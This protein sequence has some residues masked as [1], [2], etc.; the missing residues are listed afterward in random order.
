[1]FMQLEK[2]ALLAGFFYLSI[3]IINFLSVEVPF[4]VIILNLTIKN[5]FVYFWWEVCILFT[6]FGDI[7]MNIALKSIIL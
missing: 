2:L 4:L 3:L 5:N 6:I 7:I 1:M